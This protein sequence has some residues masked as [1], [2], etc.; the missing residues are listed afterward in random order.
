MGMEPI[1]S[2]SLWYL[3]QF[4]LY[5]LLTGSIIK[6]FLPKMLLVML[7]I[8]G[9]ERCLEQFN[10]TKNTL[11]RSSDFILGKVW[12][13]LTLKTGGMTPKKGR[14]AL[15]EQ[16]GPVNPCLWTNTYPLAVAHKCK[17]QDP[18]YVSGKISL[19]LDVRFSGFWS[20]TVVWGSSGLLSAVD[21]F[22]FSFSSLGFK[23]WIC[24]KFLVKWCRFETLYISAIF[25]LISKCIS[26]RHF[27]SS[28]LA[29]LYLLLIFLAPEENSQVI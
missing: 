1:R 17:T 21:I 25:P 23:S 3:F 12:Q 28:F 6:T 18:V 8:T 10:G 29:F 16:A 5:A 7:L 20:I 19:A 13:S 26:F 14:Q 24:L 27:F 9:T 11:V 22:T 4:L 2:I 15:S